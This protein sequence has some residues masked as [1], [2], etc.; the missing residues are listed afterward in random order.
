MLFLSKL[1]LGT[2]KVE[3]DRKEDSIE[4]RRDAQNGSFGGIDAISNSTGTAYN[5]DEKFH[6]TKG[7]TTGEITLSQA[8][9]SQ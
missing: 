3:A 9:A 2:W 8:L 5:S 1:R 6:L 4:T 7:N